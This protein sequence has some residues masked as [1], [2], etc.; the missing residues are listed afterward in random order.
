[1]LTG[2]QGISAF[3]ASPTSG[4]TRTALRNSCTRWACKNMSARSGVPARA[5]ASTRRSAELLHS[6]AR[7]RR[8][9]T[10]SS[11]TVGRGGAVPGWNRTPTIVVYA[12]MTSI[13]GPVSGPTSWGMATDRKVDL[14]PARGQVPLHIRRLTGALDP[15]CPHHPRQSRQRRTLNVRLHHR[16]P[17]TEA[18]D[19]DHCPARSGVKTGPIMAA[20]PPS[21]DSPSGAANAYRPEVDD[22]RPGLR[23]RAHG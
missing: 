13:S 2:C 21:A 22:H 7:P 19:R 9:S 18:P 1:M 12:G 3:T 10:K 11:S 20:C 14:D 15:D 17:R 23:H 4:S 5:I 6:S 16:H 8:W